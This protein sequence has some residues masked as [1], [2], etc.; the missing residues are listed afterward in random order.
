MIEFKFLKKLMLIKQAGQKS[1]VFVTID[2]FQMKILSL[3]D[4]II[5]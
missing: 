1:W 2:T 3:T 5:Y 4:V